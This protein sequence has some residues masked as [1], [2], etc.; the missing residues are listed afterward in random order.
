M[1]ALAVHE[2]CQ[3]EHRKQMR[4]RAYQALTAAMDLSLHN[5]G[6]DDPGL[7]LTDAHKRTWW[8]TVCFVPALLLHRPCC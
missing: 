1:L 4:A 7:T 2:Y 5:L 8:M 6:V 3:A